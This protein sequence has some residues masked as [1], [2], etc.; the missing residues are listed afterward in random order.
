MNIYKLKA[1]RFGNSGGMT[2][3]GEWSLPAPGEADE[4]PEDSAKEVIRAVNVFMTKARRA[5]V[6]LCHFAL[7]NCETDREDYYSQT[8]TY[9]P[10]WYGRGAA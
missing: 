3:F 7:W 10:D 2:E 4:A 8:I 9:D 6:D 5:S 1:Y